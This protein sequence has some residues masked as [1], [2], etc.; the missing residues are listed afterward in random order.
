[1]SALHK[2]LLI[3]DDETS[4]DMLKLRL[5]LNGFEVACAM[6]GKA[7]IHAVTTA[8]PDLILLDMNLPEMDGWAVAAC[9]KAHGDTAGIPIIGVSAHA[10]AGD[11]ERAL[12]AGC[13]EYETKPLE[14]ARLLPKMERLLKQRLT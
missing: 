9:F 3:E 10:M 2:I 1:M 12:K 8:A 4:R 11:R 13:D 6:D 14:W 5:E 7:G